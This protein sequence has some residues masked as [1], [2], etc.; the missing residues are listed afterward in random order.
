M[1]SGHDW[2]I[3]CEHGHR[4]ECSPEHVKKAR[5]A[6]EDLCKWHAERVH[7]VKHLYQFLELRKFGFTLTITTH[8][9]EETPFETAEISLRSTNVK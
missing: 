6:R 7:K 5:A 8:P 4:G 1:G 3:T 2:C 9:N